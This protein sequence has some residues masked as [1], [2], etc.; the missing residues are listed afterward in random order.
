MLTIISDTGHQK[1][2]INL[3]LFNSVA[4]E[5][6][7]LD[8]KGLKT[9]VFLGQKIESQNQSFEELHHQEVKTISIS[10]NR[11]IVDVIKAIFSIYR[12]LRLPNKYIH[13]RGPS[14][15]MLVALVFAPFFKSR[16]FWFKYANAWNENGRSKLWDL[17]KWM[18]I[19][20]KDIKVTV[21][22]N[23]TNL[24]K[25]IIPFENPC[26]YQSD[27]DQFQK[28]RKDFNQPKKL[29]FVGRFTSAK[30]IFRILDGLESIENEKIESL[31]FVGDGPEIDKLSQAVANHPLKSKIQI[32]GS[33]SKSEVMNTLKEAHFLMLPT[34]SPEGFP[35]VV[36]EAW[37]NKCIPVVSD[38]SSIPQ[39]VVEGKTGILWSRG[40]EEWDSG[41][42]R[43]FQVDNINATKMFES[44]DKLLPKFTYEYFGDRIIK[45]VFEVEK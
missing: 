41:V 44:I 15:P 38:I 9:T 36:A 12:I 37:A 1:N 43:A 34:L 7:V 27:L 10:L 5:L 4:K 20:N 29:V 17:Q 39:Y 30:G 3:F 33:Q 22:G 16:K 24:P 6:N 23:W 40:D 13:V 8:E 32:L 19:R 18:L 14:F 11:K 42:L 2:E 25:H 21:N 31:K 26:F 45:E 35:K 28:I